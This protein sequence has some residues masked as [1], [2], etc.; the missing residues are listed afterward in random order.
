MWVSTRP[1]L[2]SVEDHGNSFKLCT[3]TVHK[4]GRLGGR[5]GVHGEKAPA[6][7]SHGPSLSLWLLVLLLLQS[8]ALLLEEGLARELNPKQQ[9]PSQAAQPAAAPAGGRMDEDDDSV[10]GGGR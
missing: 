4:V 1:A 8:G 2:L 3:C 9:Q 10:G 6:T 7:G 5:E